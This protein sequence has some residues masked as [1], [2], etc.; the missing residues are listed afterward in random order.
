MHLKKLQSAYVWNIY[1]Q[2]TEQFLHK[3]AGMQ[4][5]QIEAFFKPKVLEPLQKVIRTKIHISAQSAQHNQNQNTPQK[6]YLKLKLVI[7]E[8]D[9]NLIN[10]TDF[11]HLENYIQQMNSDKQYTAPLRI[12]FAG[13]DSQFNDFVHVYVS[14][15]L[16]MKP[17]LLRDQ[18]RY[19]EIEPNDR[20]QTFNVSNTNNRSTIQ[21]QSNQNRNIQQPSVQSFTNLEFRVYVVPPPMSINESDHVDQTI[22]T[23]AHYIAM[24][25]QLY[26]CNIYQQFAINPL[27]NE[28]KTSTTLSDLLNNSIKHYLEDACR[29]LN[30]NIFKIELYETNRP[31]MVEEHF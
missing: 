23:L 1:R 18:E 6:D 4:H 3:T 14:K 2:L 11:K 29:V 30:L 24:R 31:K 13:N 26:C 5:K 15:V 28:L 12:L 22:N 9:Q 20:R 27:S 10:K 25:D 19:K 21:S 17:I 16:Q 8:T 7:P